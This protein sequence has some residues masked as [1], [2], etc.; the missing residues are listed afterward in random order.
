MCDD[1][2]KIYH[3]KNNP[4]LSPMYKILNDHGIKYGIFLEDLEDDQIAETYKLGDIYKI[5]ISRAL[6]FQ[7]MIHATA[8][9]IAHLNIMAQNFIELSSESQNYS[10]KLFVN[11]VNNA[12][13]HP[14]VLNQVDSFGLS[15][16]LHFGRL[17]VI[18]EN[19]DQKVEYIINSQFNEEDQ[20]YRLYA[21][22]ITLFDI[23]NTVNDSREKVLELTRKNVYV[24]QAFSASIN[25][26]PEIILG[27]PVSVQKQYILRFLDNLEIPL[28]EIDFNC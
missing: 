25:I 24:N 20:R 17:E 4:V 14:Y 27:S 1:A 16:S 10:L 6:S 19:N 9:E 11:A 15:N 13:S 2:I 8:H 21:V 3:L 22:G 12:I 23:W 28:D 5:S 26:F 7:D 18:L